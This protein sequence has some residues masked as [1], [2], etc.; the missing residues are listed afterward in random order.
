MPTTSRS[1][2]TSGNNRP[3]SHSP[4]ASVASLC[5]ATLLL[6]AVHLALSVGFYQ[7]VGLMRVWPVITRRRLESA[8]DCV[9]ESTLALDC[10]CTYY[11]KFTRC[12]HRSAAL[13]ALLRVRGH[14]ASLVIGVRKFPF[15]AHAW[16]ELNG[17]IINDHSDLRSI[18]AVIESVPAK[19]LDVRWAQ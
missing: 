13:V 8:E 14:A 10:A 1:V 2:G 4:R 12:L 9:R 16:V 5:L 19:P 18:F 6:A 11:P 3:P 15:L 17:C 7:L